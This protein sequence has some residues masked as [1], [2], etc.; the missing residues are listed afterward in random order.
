VEDNAMKNILLILTDQQRHDTI[1]GYGNPIIRTPALRRL[2]SEGTFYSRA[3]TP[4]PVCVPARYSLLAGVYPHHSGCADNDVMPEGRRSIMELLKEHGYQTHGVGKMHFTFEHGGDMALWGFDGRDTSEEVEGAA[5]D[6]F[7]DYLAANGFEH[8]ED[9]HGVRGEMYYVPQPSQLPVRHHNTTWAVDRSIDYLKRRDPARPFF[10]MTS[11]I[12]PHPPFEA[13]V[14]WNKLYR[15][16]EM[17]LPNVP[18]DYES[19]LTYWNKVQNRYK[20]RDRGIDPNLVR[21]MKAYY[22][23]CI[24]L[25]DENIGRLLQYMESE[26]LTKD[27]LVI[28]TSDHGEMLGDYN[29]FGKRGFLDSCARIPFIIRDPRVP[30][31]ERGRIVNTAVSLVDLFPTM[32]EY[33]GAIPSGLTDGAILSSL[34][35]NDPCRKVYSQFS[36]GA[37][38]LYMLADGRFKY[39]HSCPDNKDYLLDA[40]TDP[41]ETRNL[42]Y[43]LMYREKVSEMRQALAR[44]LEMHGHTLPLK[45]HDFAEFEMRAMAPDPDAGLLFQDGRPRKDIPHYERDWYGG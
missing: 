10:L 22:Y 18:H 20:Y 21:C 5:R 30:D 1:E 19:L 2:A 16:P 42:A 4:S 13:P 3:Y 24:S 33:A 41:M 25:I 35:V 37:D 44:N 39:F 26:G 9:V 23:A 32:A 15:A 7:H 43:N 27:T 31:R 28:F 34:P 14:P 17:P 45:E 6:D 8:V 12:K 11:F 36:Q 29:S 40:S 38:G